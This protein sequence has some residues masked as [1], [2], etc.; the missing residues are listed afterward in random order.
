[1]LVDSQTIPAWFV[2]IVMVLT[3][4]MWIIARREKIIIDS[5]I[6]ALTYVLEGLVYGVIFQ[7]F[8]VDTETRGFFVRLM[9]L[10]SCLSI[11][12]HKLVYRV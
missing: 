8:S 2:S 9:I 6:F 7:L 10:I 11:K 3:G 5:R 12:M 4:L 1:M